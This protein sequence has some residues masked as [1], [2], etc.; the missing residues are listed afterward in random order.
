MEFV[1]ICQVLSG[2]EPADIHDLQGCVLCKERLTCY[3]Y[4]GTGQELWPVRSLLSN[5]LEKRATYR[6]S[7]LD[8][9]CVFCSLQLSLEIFFAPDNTEK[10]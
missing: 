9:K 3:G 6:K 5:W 4:A 1:E 2:S 10:V 8:T 7:L